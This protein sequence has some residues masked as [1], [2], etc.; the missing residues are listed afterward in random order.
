MK[1][2]ISNL[3]INSFVRTVGLVPHEKVVKYYQSA[4]LFVFSS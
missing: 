2:V 3:K 1:E 4:D